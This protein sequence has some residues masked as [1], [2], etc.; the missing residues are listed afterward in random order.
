MTLTPGERMNLKSFLYRAEKTVSHMGA[1]SKYPALRV[2]YGRIDENLKHVPINIIQ[3]DSLNSSSTGT[4]FG[5]NIKKVDGGIM[6]SA[7]RIPKDHLFAE[8]GKVRND[9]ALTLLHEEAH[10]VLPDSA[11]VFTARVGLQPYHAD[12][13]MADV[14]SAHVARNMGFPKEVIGRHLYNRRTYFG[15][16]IDRFALEGPRGVAEEIRE[17]RFRPEA[18]RRPME[19]DAIRAPDEPVHIMP[20]GRR[21]INEIPGVRKQ[22]GRFSPR[23][24]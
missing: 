15:F 23:F 22:R 7:I 17:G 18:T 12:E 16:P 10:V 21:W 9:G 11:K 3:G 13:F 2:I 1:I 6:K 14:L 20:T 24:A 5:E 19:R 4:V 8:N